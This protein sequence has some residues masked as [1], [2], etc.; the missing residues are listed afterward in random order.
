MQKGSVTL[1]VILIAILAAAS[2]GA[3]YWKSNQESKPMATSPKVEKPISNPAVPPTEPPKPPTAPVIPTSAVNLQN[4]WLLI[5]QMKAA[6]QSRDLAA[7][8]KLGYKPFPP[9]PDTATCNQMLDF[10]S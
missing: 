7:I 6:L 1:V 4:P 2:G 5:E 3:Y 8:N 10:L 9:C